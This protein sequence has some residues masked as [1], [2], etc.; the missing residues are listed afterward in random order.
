MTIEEL[1]E[2]VRLHGLWVQGDPA[3]QRAYLQGADLQGADLRGAYLDQ[4]DMAALLFRVS[5]V[6]E[7]GPF[8]AFKAVRCAKTRKVVILQLEVPGEAERLGGL[9]G[10]K[11]RVS[12]AKVMSAT[13]PDGKPFK[14]KM[15]SDR[16]AEFEYKVGATV[17]P[18]RFDPDPR[19]ECSNGIHVFLTRMEAVEY[20]D[21]P[22][23]RKLLDALYPAP[24]EQAPTTGVAV[25][26]ADLPPNETPQA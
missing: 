24:V 6:P 17:T 22:A 25:V 26:T 1:R 13:T 19:D 9:V 12:A 5:I 2:K 3:G 23:A 20:F 11:C 21:A 4:K 16:R 7:V 10:R 14:G 8:W 18:D 15:V